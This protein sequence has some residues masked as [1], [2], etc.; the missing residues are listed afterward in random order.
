MIYGKERAG[1]WHCVTPYTLAFIACRAPDADVEVR[2]CT[3]L[4]DLAAALLCTRSPAVDVYGLHRRALVAT[5]A[6]H[7][8]VGDQAEPRDHDL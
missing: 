8:A 3:T 7:V 2:S 6:H 5:R 4:W 1:L